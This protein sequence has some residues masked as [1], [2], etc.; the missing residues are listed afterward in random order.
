MLIY[1]SHRAVIGT[2]PELALRPVSSLNEI[3]DDLVG[4][5]LVWQ[6]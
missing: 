1:E 3:I 2:F 6:T 4:R 5:F